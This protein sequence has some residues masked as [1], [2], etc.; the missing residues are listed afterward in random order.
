MSAILACK[1]GFNS[2]SHSGTSETGGEG[3]EREREREPN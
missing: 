1:V 3:V 2:I